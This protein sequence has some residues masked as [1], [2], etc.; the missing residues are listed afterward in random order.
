MRSCSPNTGFFERPA[1]CD[2]LLSEKEVLAPYRLLRNTNLKAW[3]SRY[4]ATVQAL[5]AILFLPKFRGATG[6]PERTRSRPGS[7]LT[8][9]NYLRLTYWDNRTIDDLRPEVAE[10]RDGFEDGHLLERAR[11]AVGATA[12]EHVPP[13]LWRSK[14]IRTRCWAD[15]PKAAD[16]M[17]ALSF[18][19]NLQI[20]AR[21]WSGTPQS[22]I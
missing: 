4:S 12:D 3:N 6:R 2:S 13:I 17:L 22:S 21:S 18:D 5:V 10:R 7:P 16:G 1:V 20:N 19:R 15:R 9:Q 8:Q 11:A 14:H